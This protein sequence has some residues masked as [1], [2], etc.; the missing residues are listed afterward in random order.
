M[1]II[2]SVSF[3]GVAA[4]WHVKHIVCDTI[5]SCVDELLHF[6]QFLRKL[7]L[8]VQESQGYHPITIILNKY[9]GL[10]ITYVTQLSCAFLQ[11]VTE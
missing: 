10:I 9:Y 3:A 2:Q 1:V 7:D 11:Q 6:L 5:G 4:I 8:E